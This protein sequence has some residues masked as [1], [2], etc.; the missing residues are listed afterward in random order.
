MA[1]WI[2][3]PRHF[4]R[5]ACIVCAQRR[6]AVGEAS[7]RPSVAAVLAPAEAKTEKDKGS[8]WSLEAGKL[9]HE[10]LGAPQLFLEF[11]EA[12]VWV[13][14]SGALRSEARVVSDRLRADGC[15]MAKVWLGYTHSSW[16]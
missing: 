6:E 15:L 16:D 2:I 8:G 1:T 9:G 11:A 3:P 13:A 10:S 12:E 5:E 14:D 7:S 4:L